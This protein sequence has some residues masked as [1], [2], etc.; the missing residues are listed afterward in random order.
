MSRYFH[1][2]TTTIWKLWAKFNEPGTVRECPQMS[3]SNCGQGRYIVPTTKKISNLGYHSKGMKNY[4]FQLPSYIFSK[5]PLQRGTFASQTLIQRLWLES[6]KIKLRVCIN[7]KI[8]KINRKMCKTDDAADGT[9][10][11]SEVHCFN[12]VTFLCRD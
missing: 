1:Q 8:S 5:R 9:A 6:E 12:K 11:D 3:R 7:E 10:Y 4:D 2:Q